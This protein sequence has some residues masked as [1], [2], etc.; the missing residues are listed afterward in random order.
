M[1][2]IFKAAPCLMAFSIKRLK[3]EAGICALFT[4]IRSST[5]KTARR[6]A[7]S[8]SQVVLH[9]AQ[10]F[11]QADH[12]PLGSLQA[13]AGKMLRQLDGQ[14]ARASFRI[15]VDQYADGVEGIEQEMRVDLRDER[16]EPR[17]ASPAG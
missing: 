5:C 1:V 17:S 7:L 10:F 8:Q 9:K 2:P 16:I 13:F 14:T 4:S 15:L 12:F 3:S 11:L 6:S